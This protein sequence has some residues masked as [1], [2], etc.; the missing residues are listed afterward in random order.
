MTRQTAKPLERLPLSH[1]NQPITQLA[2][3]VETG[4]YIFDD[5]YQRGD[6]WTDDQRIALV[7]SLLVGATIPSITVSNRRHSRWTG[8]PLPDGVRGW[9]AVIDGRQ[10]LTTVWMWLRGDLAVP[11]SWFPADEVLDTEDTDDGPYVRFTGLSPKGQD[12][13]E[14]PAMLTADGDFNSVADEAR[15]YKVINGGGTPQTAE[16]M[17]RA[18]RVAEEG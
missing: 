9:H 2:R 12:R 7:Y 5:S 6:V 8:D 1:G 14:R 4:K 18:A 10:R 15:I 11:A 16:D 17:A 3:Y 13:A